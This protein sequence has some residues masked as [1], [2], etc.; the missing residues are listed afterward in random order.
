MNIPPTAEESYAGLSSGQA[1]EALRKE[2]FNE[3]PGEKRR[4]LLDIAIETMKEPMFLLLVSCGTLYLILGDLESALLLLLFVL[5]VILITIYQERKVERALDALKD[6]SSPRARV[7]RDGKQSVIPGKEIVRDDIVILGEG[8]RVPADIVLLSCTNMAIDESLLTGEPV[9]VRKAPWDGKAGK[10]RPGGDDL[11]FAYSSTLVTQGRGI[12]RVI[13]TGPHTEVGKIGKALRSIE[14]EHTEL[15]EETGRL[16]RLFGLIGG[17][18]CIAVIAIWGLTR[19]DWIDGFLA[20][21]SLAMALLPE[22]FPV[23]LTVFLALGAWRM[24]KANVLTRRME[25]IQNLGSATVLCSDKTGTLTMNQ[26]T[27][28]RIWAD[29]RSCDAE[30]DITEWAVPVLENAVLAS[31]KEPFDPMER[32]IRKAGAERIPGSLIFKGRWELVREYPLSKQLLALSH[33][34][35]RKDDGYLVASKGAPEAILDLCHMPEKGREGVLDAVRS[36][37]DGGFRVLGVAKAKTEKLTDSQH[38]FD[39][40]F[41]G[42]IAFED[43]VRPE[44]PK[45]V[46][47]CLD[48]G[49]RVIMITGDYPGTAI[50]VAK[51]AGFRNPQS[52]ITGPELERMDDE[53]LHSRIR[54]TSVFARVV[55]EQKLRIVRAL[56]KRN[57][58]VIMTGDGVNDA[59]ALKAAEIGI[60]M[61]NRGTDVAR[62]SASLVLTDDNFTSIVGGARM[63]RRIYDNIRKAMG[64]IVS[65]HIPIA[66][67]TLMPVVL[68]WPIILFPV[69]IAFLELAIDPVCSV[70]YEAEPEDKRIMKRKPRKRGEPLFTSR[71]LI[72]S[73]LRGIVVL[74]MTAAIFY[75]VMSQ[76]YEVEKARTIAFA[77]L[78]LGN[79]GIILSSRSDQQSII[80]TI[81]HKNDALWIIALVTL[82]LLLLVINVPFFQELFRMDELGVRAIGLAFAGAL[83]C[84]IAFEVL[85]ITERVHEMETA[86]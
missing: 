50:A 37:S 29:G 20:G 72:G 51:K 80:Q 19:G 36:L 73:V 65:I 43:P 79:F 82:F 17:L 1:E 38:D 21:L 86:M 3:L 76:G 31:Q 11:P 35:R 4:T 47:E 63:G 45:A 81:T 58:V 12:G 33:V 7:I 14:H 85:K 61:G 70:V 60:A 71:M 83:G 32:A 23:V 10:P 41:V 74:L 46:S 67:L 25:A 68:G 34:W 22:E 44:V 64:Y 53:E 6:L 78:I 2:G 42:L 59:P 57:E 77:T 84:V 18:V 55:P 40:G 62:E 69:H 49:I 27:L 48:A 8:D 13:S 15:Q 26:M 24:S 39:F 52:V 5:V 16:V 66:G 30:G 9:P 56:K 75:F 54:D 28:K